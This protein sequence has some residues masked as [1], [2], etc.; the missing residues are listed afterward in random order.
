[1]NHRVATAQGKTGNSTFFP[2]R[3]STEIF[4]VTQSKVLRRR[5]VSIDSRGG[6]AWS[7]VPPSGGGVGAWSW[8]GGYP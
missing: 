2:D 8:V 4:A 6:Y 3:E 5:R 7:Q 1:M